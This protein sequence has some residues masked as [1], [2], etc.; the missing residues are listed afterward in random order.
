MEKIFLVEIQQMLI[1]EN[2]Y[3]RTFYQKSLTQLTSGILTI[4]I[5]VIFVLYKNLFFFAR[6]NRFLYFW[7]FECQIS[8]L[9]FLN[10]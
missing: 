3:M 8:A 2:M 7:V 10:H 1:K 4:K 9:R 6:L 5:G